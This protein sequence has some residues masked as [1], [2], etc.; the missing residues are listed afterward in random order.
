MDHEEALETACINLSSMPA[1]A[2]LGFLAGSKGT[3]APDRGIFNP[4]LRDG[5][6]QC[7]HESAT[8][9]WLLIM[10]C[11]AGHVGRMRSEQALAPRA[12]MN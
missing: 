12:S 10:L 8:R 11:Q 3:R 6:M 9:R 2:Y 7:L 4:K 1:R 5:G